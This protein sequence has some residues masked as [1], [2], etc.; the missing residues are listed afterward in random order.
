MI[1]FDADGR[2]L[3]QRPGI[4]GGIEVGRAFIMDCSRHVILGRARNHDHRGGNQNSEAFHE[5]LVSILKCLL[6][7]RPDDGVQIPIP[8]QD[9]TCPVILASRQALSGSIRPGFF[10]DRGGRFRTRFAR[11]L[12]ERRLIPGSDA[13]DVYVPPPMPPE[14]LTPRAPMI[15]N[16]RILRRGNH[17]LK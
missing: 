15:V 9:C 3:V 10:P 1:A 16:R 5:P 14:P 13:N 11:N 8:R 17:C 4:V 12:A 2:A 6:L 7:V